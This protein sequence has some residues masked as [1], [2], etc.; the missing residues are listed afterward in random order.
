MHEITYYR[1]YVTALAYSKRC[2]LALMIR[3]GT[4]TWAQVGGDRSIA[5]RLPEGVLIDYV[6]TPTTHGVP[7]S[8]VPYARFGS[9]WGN[10]VVVSYDWDIEATIEN[11][12]LIINA[13]YA[14]RENT[15]IDAL[16]FMEEAWSAYQNTLKLLEQ[17]GW[18]E[19]CKEEGA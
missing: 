1:G 16:A 5:E 6:G 18:S 10:P 13:A 3:D 9:G 11:G 7:Y 8:S 15:I 14:Y 2:S 17:L 12:E 4:I 19:Y